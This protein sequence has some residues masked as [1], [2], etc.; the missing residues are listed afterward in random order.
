MVS[1][2]FSHCL[3]IHLEAINVLLD[4]VKKAAAGQKVLM[5]DWATR[6]PTLVDDVAQVLVA[7]AGEPFSSW[8][9]QRTDNIPS[10]SLSLSL[11]SCVCL[12]VLM[13]TFG[14]LAT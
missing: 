4:G 9:Y 12:C 5:D 13:A 3:Y 6:F 14:E 11:S 7:L 1:L 10:L 8:T 2:L